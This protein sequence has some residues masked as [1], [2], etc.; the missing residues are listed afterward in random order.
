MIQSTCAQEAYFSW[1]YS[2]NDPGKQHGIRMML[3][4][5]IVGPTARAKEVCAEYILTAYPSPA[6]HAKT[7]AHRRGP[8][9]LGDDLAHGLRLPVRKAEIADTPLYLVDGIV[10][11]DAGS[12]VRVGPTIVRVLRLLQ[13][14]T[15][16]T[17][18]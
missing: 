2:S 10:G 11:F 9:K 3:V 14:A 5:V 18:H 16:T 17:K 12:G 13:M 1:A 8:S 6:K 4:L 15:M 7:L